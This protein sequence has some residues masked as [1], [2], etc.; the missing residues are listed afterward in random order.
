MELIT[1][2]NV[3]LYFGDRLLLD[4]PNFKIYTGDRIGIVGANGSGKTTF[5]NILSGELESDEGNIRVNGTI[6]YCKQFFE[7]DIIVEDAVWHKKNKMK[8][9]VSDEDNHSGGEKQRVQLSEIFSNY[10]DIY[11]FDEPTSNLDYSG[12][13]LLKKEF[14]K[15][16][17]FLLV[18]HDR[19]LLDECCTKIVEISDSKLTLYEGNY[20]AYE[21]QKKQMVERKSFEY[22][23]YVT[24]KKRLQEEYIAKTSKAK[25][26]A[27]KPKDRG[28]LI[29]CE[30]GG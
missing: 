15:L 21:Y 30:G 27:K 22:Q 5:L 28:Q 16:N 3:K 20:T 6:T 25:K 11:F 9:G 7:K 24:E 26:M 18:S 10:A 2:T 29:K 1:I 23:Q 12:I 14:V 8:F 17:T 4:I 13:L 19:A